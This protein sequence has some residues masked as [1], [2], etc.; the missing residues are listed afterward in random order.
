MAGVSDG[1][2]LLAG[3]GGTETSVP[4]ATGTGGLAGFVEL[5]LGPAFGAV[6]EGLLRGGGPDIGAVPPP[7]AFAVACVAGGLMGDGDSVDSAGETDAL[8]TPSLVASAGGSA[9]GGC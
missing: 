6:V 1:C 8:V 7:A 5:L 4:G 2:L 9:D 3:G